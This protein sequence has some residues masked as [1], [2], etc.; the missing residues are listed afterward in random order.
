MKGEAADLDA[1]I[2][3][4]LG[5]KKAGAPSAVARS[6]GRPYDPARLALFRTLHKALLDHPPFPRPAPAASPTLAFYEA[7]FSNF[8]EGAEFAV[9]EA[10]DIVFRGAI[11]E[12]RPQDSHEALGTWRLVSDDREMTRIPGDFSAF[13]DCLRSRHATIMA[14]RPDMRPGAFKRSANQAGSTVFVAPD[15]VEGTLE[16]GFALLQSLDTPFQR[17]AF[18]MFLVA[19]VHPF[20]AV[21]GERRIVIP[22]VFHA[23][24]V[25]A[26]KALSQGGHPATSVLD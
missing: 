14:R 20:V 11:S 6:R 19:E 2:G 22:T 12:E 13:M 16:Q 9:E 8:V 15:L 26:L 25:A 3:A 5:T 21:A 23:N 18:V 10:A 17:A 24:Y 7:Y 4:L 1:L